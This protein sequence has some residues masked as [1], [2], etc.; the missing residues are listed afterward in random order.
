MK[1]DKSDKW[2]LLRDEAK[3]AGKTLSAARKI[4]TGAEIP[5]KKRRFKITLE[6]VVTFV[7]KFHFSKAVKEQQKYRRRKKIN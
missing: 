2:V 1:E 7:D 6:V 4:V 5:A 3:R